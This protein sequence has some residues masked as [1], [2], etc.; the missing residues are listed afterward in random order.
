MSLETKCFGSLGE[1]FARGYLQRTG[2]I[3]KYAPF[4]CRAGEI[5][6]VATEGDTLVFIE[7]KSR[8]TSQFGHPVEAVNVQ[9]QR[10]IIR[11]ARHFLATVHHIAYRFCRFDV[12]GIM[13]GSS[14]SSPTVTHIRDAFRDQ[15]PY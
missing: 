3:I 6:I 12:L 15:S 4:R 7:V 5:D 2:F 13:Q 8:R 1:H 10:R 9:K 11:V 14:G